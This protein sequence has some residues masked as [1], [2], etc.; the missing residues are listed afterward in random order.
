M[1]TNALYEAILADLIEVERITEGKIQA[2]IGRRAD[3]LVSLL[4]EQI[5]PMYRLNTRTLEMGGLSESEKAE[6]KTHITRWAS[7]EEHLADLI[8]QHLG[9]IAYLRE[10][11]GIGHQERPGLNL[12]L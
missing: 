7:R 4:Q 1:T 6:L 11:L 2:V 12:G 5:D 10:L 8:E 9:Y 3:T